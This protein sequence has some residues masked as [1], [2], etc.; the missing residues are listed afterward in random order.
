MRITTSIDMI[1]GL[2]VIV[3]VAVAFL[4]Y[5]RDAIACESGENESPQRLAGVTMLIA[6]RKVRPSGVAP[7][8]IVTGAKSRAARR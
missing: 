1:G 2:G 3:D 8:S 4:F 6:L 7:A 5:M